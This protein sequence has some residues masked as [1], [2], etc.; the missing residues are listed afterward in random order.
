MNVASS[1]VTRPRDR[2]Q[3]VECVAH[4]DEVDDQ[5]REVGRS[6]RGDLPVA[7][8]DDRVGVVAGVAPPPER[9]L[10]HVHER[11]DLIERV[12]HPSAPERGA[13]PGLV[14]AG[15]RRRAVE[16]A[17]GEEAGDAP[18]ARPQEAADH[19]GSEQQPEPERGVAQ[20]RA[21]AAAHE[22]LDPLAGH[23]GVVP[24]GRHEPHPL[25]RVGTGSDQ[26]V[27]TRESG[28]AGHRLWIMP[29]PGPGAGRRPPG[30]VRSGR[31]SR[32]DRTPRIRPRSAA[33]RTAR[34]RRAAPPHR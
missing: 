22:L 15:V 5:P 33:G 29:G 28:A 2:G 20:R 27:V 21:V 1:A 17:V 14:P 25:G 31:S 18:G 30:C 24:L 7:P 10:L 12:V 16:H 13:M 23:L 3:R 8:D 32:P 9:R 19:P 6:H 26:R 4:A 34:G 11:G